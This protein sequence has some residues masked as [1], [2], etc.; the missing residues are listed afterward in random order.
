MSGLAT[1]SASPPDENRPSFCA[2]TPMHS[3]SAAR[4][5]LPVPFTTHSRQTLRW[6]CLLMSIAAVFSVLSVV[7]SVTDP[8]LLTKVQ[9]MARAAPRGNKIQKCPNGK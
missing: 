5:K 8:E 9:V 6:L 3:F 7:N 2:F 4:Q 1:T